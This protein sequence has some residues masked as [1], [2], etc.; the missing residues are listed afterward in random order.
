M[1]VTINTEGL[2]KGYEELVIQVE[3]TVTEAKKFY[4]G[5]NKAASTRAR[6]AMSNIIKIS[7][8]NRAQILKDRS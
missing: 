8:E 2:P 3:K 6:T 4:V 5:G 1:E 7:K